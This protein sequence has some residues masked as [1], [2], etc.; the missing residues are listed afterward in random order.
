MK[1]HPNRRYDKYN[2]N[3]GKRSQYYR[4]HHIGRFEAVPSRGNRRHKKRVGGADR[5]G[6]RREVSIKQVCEMLDVDP[7][8]L[9]RWRKRGYLVPAEI[10]GKRRYKISDIR[11]ILN[12]RAAQ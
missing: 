11:R 2:V 6:Q 9:W 5:R 7:S 4:S 1:E 12:G 10:G 3:D 8:S